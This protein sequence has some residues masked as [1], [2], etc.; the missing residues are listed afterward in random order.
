[1]AAVEFITYNEKRY[2]VK[3]GIYSLM[4]LQTKDGITLEDI[5]VNP[6][7]YKPV[8]FLA[9]Q[10]GARITKETLDIKED[11]MDLVLDECFV[12]FNLLFPKF[13]PP[14][15]MEKLMEVGG[16]QQLMDKKLQKAKQQKKSTSKALPPKP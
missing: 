11:D 16:M 8:L 4:L 13:F 7:L 12:E 9:L 3:L 5:E 15:M 2:P 14:E 6:E 10:Q 1:M